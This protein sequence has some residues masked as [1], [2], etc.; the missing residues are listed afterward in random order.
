MADLFAPPTQ[1]E[2][3]DRKIEAFKNLLNN[4]HNE[5]E[6]LTTTTTDKITLDKVRKVQE[7]LINIYIWADYLKN[8][9]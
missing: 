9:I 8:P 5:I 2:L 1:E 4:A 7:G 3:L 6:L